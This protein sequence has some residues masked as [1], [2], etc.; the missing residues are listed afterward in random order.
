MSYEPLSHSCMTEIMCRLS[1]TS[2]MQVI[3]NITFG[4][5]GRTAVVLAG[6]DAV[7][8]GEA[9]IGRGALGDAPP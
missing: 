9:E 5:G 8:V 4:L 2:M 6:D 1:R 7:P 3:C